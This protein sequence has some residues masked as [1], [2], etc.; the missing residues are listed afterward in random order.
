MRDIA[1]CSRFIQD[2]AFCHT[3]EAPQYRRG[4]EG[5]RS[6]FEA[7]ACKLPARLAV[8]CLR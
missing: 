2:G 6:V 3:R 7:T 8:G 5:R 4:L 1:T